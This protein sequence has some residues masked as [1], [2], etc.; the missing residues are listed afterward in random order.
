MKMPKAIFFDLWN[1]LLYC[2]TRERVESIIGVLGLEGRADYRSVIGEMDETVFID[3]GYPP[4][5][6][7]RGLCGK[8]GVECTGKAA[9]EAAKVWAGRLEEAAY[10]PDTEAGLGMLG[11]YKL[12]IVSNTDAAGAEYVRKRG[13]DGW[14]DLVVMS[15]YVGCA[16]P[17]P[18]I[19]GIAA[20]E[21]GVKPWDCWMVGDSLQSDVEGARKAGLNAILLARDGRK[22]AKGVMKVK[23]LEEVVSKVR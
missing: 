15:C 8:H 3:A 20:D 4:Q 18:R 16:K 22:G 7:F 2:P 19:Y 9:S 23:S 6:M 5:E 14:F 1:T 12:A 10:F 21:L 13:I 17:D 11:D